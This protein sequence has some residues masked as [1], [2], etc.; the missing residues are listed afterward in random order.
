MTENNPPDLVVSR[1]GREV[2]NDPEINKGTAFTPAERRALGLEGLLPAAVETIDEQLRRQRVKYDQLHDDLE[3]HVYLRSV[4][5]SNEVLFYRFLCAHLGEMM[6]IVYTPTVG[7]ACEEFSHIYRRPQGVFVSYPDRNRMVDQFDA[8][9]GGIDVIVVTDGQRILGL[10][11]QGVGGMGIPI[12][13]LSLYTAAGGIDPRRTLPVMLDVGTDNTELLNDPLYIGWRHERIVGAEYDDFVDQ[14][15]ATIKARFPG[16]LL[17]WEDFAGQNAAPLLAR[18][19][20]EL[21]SFND[22]MPSPRC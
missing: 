3:R 8:I 6:P 12:G 14:F 7:A 4:E 21:L 20:D 19:R 2:L 1:W 11:D 15:V 9:T 16:V 17:Q 10:G 13:K 5:D 22:D 18:Y